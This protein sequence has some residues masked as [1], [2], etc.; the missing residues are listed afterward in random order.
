M[1]EATV[2]VY[3]APGRSAAY[4]DHDDDDD[5][6][7]VV[8]I[9][10]DDGGNDTTKDVDPLIREVLEGWDKSGT[11]G[12]YTE[13]QYREYTDKR[14]WLVEE[15]TELTFTLEAPN[16]QKLY[17][18]VQMKNGDYGILVK[19]NDIK[20]HFDN[21]DANP[22]LKMDTFVLDGI[23]VSVRGSMYDDH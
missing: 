6:D 19:M 21:R 23:K 9:D 2:T 11:V 10:D 22:E 16:S 1:S 18:H 3:R 13:Y 12:S 20:F 8:D 5:D 15:T 17:T 7:D 14:I 4:N